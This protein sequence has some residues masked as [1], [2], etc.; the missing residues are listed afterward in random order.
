MIL[1]EFCAENFTNIP[2]AIASGSN[3]IELC[4]NLTVG[5]TTVSIG[6]MEE[7]IAY[8]HEKNISVMSIIRPRGGNFVYN[9]TEISMM[10]TDIIE[11]K[12]REVDGVVIGCLTSD[13]LLDEE[14]LLRLIDAAEGLSITFHMAFDV[15][16]DHN[17][18]DAIDWLANHDVARILTHGGLAGTP[19]EANYSH[20]DQLIKHADNRLI[21]LPGGGIT[22]KN[23]DSVAQKLNVKEV[24]G[25]K[26]VAI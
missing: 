24:H 17:Q 14:S 16:S 22:F 20:L 3:R 25:T 2:A 11:A 15:M 26:I 13:N 1:K 10:I 6:V 23:A 7:T 18:L 12:K 19:I 5:G 21:I 4:D 8:A 9:D